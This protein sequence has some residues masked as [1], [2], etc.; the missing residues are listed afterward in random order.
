MKEVDFTKGLAEEIYE[1]AERLN[2][3]IHKFPKNNIDVSDKTDDCSKTMQILKLKSIKEHLWNT[4]Y[5][6]EHL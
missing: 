1:I 4:A 3:Y 2:S 5:E 6:L